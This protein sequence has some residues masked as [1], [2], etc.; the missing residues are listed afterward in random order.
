[1][2]ASL[3]Y[4]PLVGLLLGL[5]LWGLD[6]VLSLVVPG[7]V[8]NG[9]LLVALVLLTGALHLDG[10]ID[11]CDGVGLQRPSGERLAIMADSRVG[12]F[13]VIGGS[14]LLVMKFA[15]LWSLPETARPAALVAMPVIGRWAMVY[16]VYAYPYARQTGGAGSVF[17]DGAVFWR[18]AVASIVALIVAV[19]VKR[20]W[21]GVVLMAGVWI[22]V[23]GI[24]AYLRRILGGLTGDSYGAVNEV[25]E[26][27]VLVLLPLIW[28]IS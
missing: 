2:G 9:I 13:G 27:L 14:L 24:T 5:V 19:M 18:M 8:V 3:A 28:M 26:V 20:D 17:K 10:F 7:A 22:F 6:V 23:L 4:F 15:A 1:M 21:H 16:A 12:A 25:A 11:T